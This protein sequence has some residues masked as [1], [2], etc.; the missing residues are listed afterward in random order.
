MKSLTGFL[1]TRYLNWKLERRPVVVKT[2]ACGV[3]VAFC[4]YTW[5]EYH[6]RALLSYVGEPDTVQWIRANLRSGDVLWDIGANVGAYSLLA[7]KLIPGASVAA[8]EPYIPTFSHLWENI[9]Q[10]GLSSQIV[11]ICVALSDR[12]A[13]D[14][15]GISD[16]RA[17]SAEHVLGR[18]D[19]KSSQPSVGIMGDDACKI[20]G[21]APPTLL[22]VD[23][24]GYEVHVLKGMASA[25]R[26]S[27]L[28]SC[29]VE[30]ERGKTEDTVDG[31]MEAADFV[32]L[33]DSSAL[34]EVPVFNVIYGRGH[35]K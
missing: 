30:V 29:I 10:N 2:Q 16:P 9:A 17:G 3:E 21:V 28:R 25:L 31:L 11:P 18:K 34:C 7:A 8:F 27:K 35:G 15:L 6:N 24:D 14:E 33:S 1:R 22:K 19:M 4:V 26:D 20:L 5:V 32:R 23:V 12:T 13:I